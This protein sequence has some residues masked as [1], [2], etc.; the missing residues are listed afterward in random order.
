MQPCSHPLYGLIDWL[1]EMSGELLRVM[2]VRELSRRISVFSEGSSL[3]SVSSQP[4]S[5]RTRVCFSKR[6]EAFETAPR[7]LRRRGSAVISRTVVIQSQHKNKY[8]TRKY[9]S[10]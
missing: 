9:D 4:S 5:T 6:P 1:K 8:R 10:W 7:P 2:M 3:S